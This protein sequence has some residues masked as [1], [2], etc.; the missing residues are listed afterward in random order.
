MSDRY[1]AI[2]ALLDDPLN[3]ACFLREAQRRKIFKA[4]LLPPPVPRADGGWSFP[5]LLQ[6]MREP[7]PR[8]VTPNEE[9]DSHYEVFQDD[10]GWFV[11]SVAKDEELGPFDSSQKARK[12]AVV[13]AEADGYTIMKSM[14]WDNGDVSHKVL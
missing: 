6:I 11:L 4:K 5:T 12:E 7:L 1:S 13:L 3:V 8:E 2:T 9:W 14:P 10:T